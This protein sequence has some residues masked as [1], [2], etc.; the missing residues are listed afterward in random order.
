[1]RVHRLSIAAC[2][3]LAWSAQAEPDESVLGKARG[4]D[5]GL[6]ALDDTAAKHAKDL[7]GSPYGDTTVRQLLRMS[8][9]LVF[10]ER[11]DG[12]DDIS[13]MSRAATD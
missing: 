3:L 12:T 11:Y 6:L 9:G 1:M 5:K 4:A 10:T 8:S 13:R 7:A 2:A